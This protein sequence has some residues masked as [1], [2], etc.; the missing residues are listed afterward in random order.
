MLDL[1]DLHSLINAESLQMLNV[2]SA[3]H[4][5]DYEYQSREYVSPGI[6]LSGDV[7][8]GEVLE[9]LS[10]ETWLYPNI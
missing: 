10:L 9:F 1:M 5:I 4:V 8:D 7:G 6:F 3:E 2:G